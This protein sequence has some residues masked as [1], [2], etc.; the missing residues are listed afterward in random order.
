MGKRPGDTARSPEEAEKR[1][2]DVIE[3]AVRRGEE[4]GAFDD[5]PGKGRPFQ[6]ESERDDDWWLA[7]HMLKSA[8]FAPE[9][10]ADGR[11]IR[12]RMAVA[13]ALLTDFESWHRDAVGREPPSALEAAR[14]VREAEFRRQAGE[15]NTAIERFNLTCPIASA[16]LIRIKPDEE[17]A[18]FRRRL[19][20]PP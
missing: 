19:A 6:W 16:H 14:S 7:N 4:S 13:R 12:E 11:R 17:I 15:V 8:G 9:W 1:Y 18:A 20:P 10:I 2:R 5:L 3:E